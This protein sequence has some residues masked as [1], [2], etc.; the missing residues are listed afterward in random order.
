MHAYTDQ[1][2]N[3]K[4]DLVTGLPR[5]PADPVEEGG[6]GVVGSSHLE[7][8]GIGAFVYRTPRRL[9]QE[10]FERVVARLPRDVYRA[11]GIIRFAGRDWQCLFNY[12]CGRSEVSWVK[13]P[14]IGDETQL[15]II[16]REP[17]RYRDRLLG[18]LARCEARS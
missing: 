8:D 3:S 4:R 18:K 16:G 9:R 5:Q 10:G 2:L 11:K 14:G 7:R 15:V 6:C 1:F 17:M 13:L 12:T